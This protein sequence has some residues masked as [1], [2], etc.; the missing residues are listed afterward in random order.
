VEHIGF[1]PMT[2]TLPVWWFWP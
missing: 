1:E 2:P